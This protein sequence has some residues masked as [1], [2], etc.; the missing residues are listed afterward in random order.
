VNRANALNEQEQHDFRNG[1]RSFP[2]I[3][4][5]MQ[6]LLA[7]TS[8]DYYEAENDF[9]KMVPLRKWVIASPHSSIHI[10][11]GGNGVQ[12]GVEELPTDYAMVL[13]H[14]FDV[15]D[16]Y[17]E[18]VD[19]G[20]SKGQDVT[21]TSI[22]KLLREGGVDPRRCFYTNRFMGLRHAESQYGPNPGRRYKP[23]VK[24]SDEM[25]SMTL[26]TI[27]PRVVF[28]LGE[29]V[30]KSLGLTNLWR[31]E[32]VARAVIEGH[33][34][35]VASL[36]HTSYPTEYNRRKI[37]YNGQVGS[38]AEVEIIEAAMRMANLL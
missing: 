14:D 17:N 38:K 19:V 27:R 28:M 16:R 24:L 8:I 6:R 7:Y 5:L 23:F 12:H 1:N 32:Y 15:L 34:V 18:A 10:F 36:T 26:A 9:P 35:V 37:R 33:A 20:Y 25:L 31:N 3:D 22:V 2:E 13:M 21:A 29:H 30:P 4:L 11:P